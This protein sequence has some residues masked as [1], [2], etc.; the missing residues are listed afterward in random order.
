MPFVAPTVNQFKPGTQ[1]RHYKGGL[2]NVVGTCLIEATLKP[3]VLYKPQQGDKQ[4]VTWM[5]PMSEFQDI[6]ATPDGSIP[7]FVLISEPE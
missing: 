3:G 5:R 1:L 2:Y 4:D 6:I 7:R